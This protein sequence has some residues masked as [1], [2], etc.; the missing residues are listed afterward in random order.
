MM[1]KFYLTIIL[2]SLLFLPKTGYSQNIPSPEGWVSDFAGVISADYKSKLDVLLQ[3]LEEKTSAEVAVVTVESIAP[4]D[5]KEYARL[6]FDNWKPGKK[7]KDNGALVIL[8][9]KE[10]YWRIEVGYGLEGILPDGLC[11]EIGRNYMVPSF[12]EG[13]YGEGLYYGAAVISHTIA[14]AAQKTL[15]ALD[16]IKN[17]DTV[18][19]E[20]FDD[21]SPWRGILIIAIFLFLLIRYI[22]WFPIGRNYY[23]SERDGYHYGYHGRG[24]LGGGGFGGGFGGF[25]GGLG[26]GGGA[27]GKF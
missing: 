2:I 1:R 24:G 20:R 12:K 18:T 15:T 11:G 8:A 9:V 22:Y 26:G 4:Y 3:E 13:R 17:L 21:F 23:R 6:L 19:Q 7:G 25:G 27:G 16:G 14:Q 5:E 10:R